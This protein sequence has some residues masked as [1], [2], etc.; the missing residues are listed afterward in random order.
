MTSIFRVG[1]LGYCKF[2]E[3]LRVLQFDIHVLFFDNK[4]CHL[5]NID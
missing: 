3:A 5:L 4:R 2:T 1:I